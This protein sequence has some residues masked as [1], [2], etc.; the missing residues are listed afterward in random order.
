[1]VTPLDGLGAGA[2]SRRNL[3]CIQRESRTLRFPRDRAP[4]P[5]PSRGVTIWRRAQRIH[6]RYPQP[7]GWL[8]GGKLLEHG[9]GCY[10]GIRTPVVVCGCGGETRA[11]TKSATRARTTAILGQIAGRTC[12]QA[13]C[14]SPRFPLRAQLLSR[15]AMG[16]RCHP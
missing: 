5:R 4:A 8:R 1:M 6:W 14:T 7:P 11:Q 16:S 2:R 9:G 15:C 13:V 3:A 10:I 12:V